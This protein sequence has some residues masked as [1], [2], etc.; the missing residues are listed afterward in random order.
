MSTGTSFGSPLADDPLAKREPPPARQRARPV[1]VVPFA[2]EPVASPTRQRVRTPNPW[3]ASTSVTGP[4]SARELIA[5]I[6]DAQLSGG[7]VTRS[8]EAGLRRWIRADARAQRSLIE[9]LVGRHDY[10]NARRAAKRHNS[11]LSVRLE[12]LLTAARRQWRTS[13]GSTPEQR[14]VRVRRLTK[15]LES[16]SAVGSFTFPAKAHRFYQRK[17]DGGIRPLTKFHWV[18]DVRLR[19]LKSALT[20]FASLHDDQYLLGQAGRRGPASAREN[21]LLALRDVGDGYA[22]LQFDIR[23]FYGSISHGWL[24]DNLPL[25]KGIVKRF[26]HTGEMQIVTP[27]ETE[28]GRRSRSVADAR[29]E[30]GRSGYAIPQGSA[31][32]SLI[33]EWVMADILRSDAVFGRLRLFTWSDNLGVLVPREE[34][35]AVEELVRAAFARHGAGPFHLT[36]KGPKPVTSE[37]DFLGVWYRVI[38]G[39]PRAYIPDAIAQAW[40]ATLCEDLPTAG[41][42]DLIAVAKRLRGKEASWSWW[43]GMSAL[44]SG[45]DARLWAAQQGLERPRRCNGLQAQR[46]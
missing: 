22:F 18:D 14:A 37:F 30:N 24:E 12:V 17:P 4:R 28:T 27:G 42:A 29:N 2:Q 20:P 38:A 16:V 21:L 6:R 8:E 3:Y 31:L 40:E 45:I 9:R 41:T 7:S 33:A 15:V 1:S 5:L 44:A 36:T 32:S 26:V 46:E 39:E 11:R 13:S 34:A 43:T 25:N 35:L 10:R 23:D 19:I